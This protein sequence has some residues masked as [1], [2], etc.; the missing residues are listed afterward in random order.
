M[1][2]DIKFTITQDPARYQ[3]KIEIDVRLDGLELEAGKDPGAA[4]IE[5]MNKDFQEIILELEKMYIEQKYKGRYAYAKLPILSGSKNARSKTQN[6]ALQ[7]I[8]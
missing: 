2:D 1:K 5:Q 7:K 6:T 3:Y 4:F 8:S